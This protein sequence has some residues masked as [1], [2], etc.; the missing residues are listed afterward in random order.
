[1][2]QLRIQTGHILSDAKLVCQSIEEDGKKLT[3]REAAERTDMVLYLRS[4]CG[5]LLSL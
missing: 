2:R 5:D 1:M 3:W 4:R